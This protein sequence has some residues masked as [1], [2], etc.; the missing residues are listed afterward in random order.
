MGQAVPDAGKEDVY[1]NIEPEAVRTDR[2]GVKVAVVAGPGAERDVEVERR[3]HCLILPLMTRNCNSMVPDLSP[4]TGQRGSA[5]FHGLDRNKEKSRRDEIPRQGYGSHAGVLS[6]TA[7][8]IDKGKLLFLYRFV[9]KTGSL[10]R[11]TTEYTEF[12]VTDSCYAGRI[13]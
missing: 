2:D 1:K 3:F 4:D 8:H 9:S 10:R 13:I 5:D 7:K 12:W 11:K 6:Y